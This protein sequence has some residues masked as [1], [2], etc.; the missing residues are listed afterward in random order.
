MSPSSLFVILT[1]LLCV[2]VGT[3]FYRMQRRG[4]DPESVRRALDGAEGLLRLIKL[5]QQHRGASAAFLS[6]DISFRTKMDELQ[7]AIQALTPKLNELARFEAS[8]LRPYFSV[9]DM[10]VLLHR[11]KEL[12][13]QIES[14]SVEQSITA[15][16]QLIAKVLEWLA[17]MGEARVEI[18]MSTRLPA[19][20]ARN[21]SHRLP[22]LA[23]CLGQARA[24]GSSVAARG[25][26]NSSSRM[27]LMFLVAR[28]QTL[29]NQAAV[30]PQGQVA[31]TAV[32]SA[33]KLLAE[34]RTGILERNTIGMDATAYFALATTAIDTVFVWADDCNRQ[35]IEAV[36]AC[37][38]SKA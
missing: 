27:R 38:A 16:S 21:F 25:E 23:E 9:H 34:I 33:E 37:A 28:A 31:G 5:L 10:G 1:V 4:N 18:P 2:A 24:L 11:W 19:D 7:S 17:D 26:C 36:E 15:H 29:L 6:G 32:M 30:Q 12:L 20:L 8:F 22:A 35:M 13:Q 3:Y 14:S